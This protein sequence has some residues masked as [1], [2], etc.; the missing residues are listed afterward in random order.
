MQYSI[1]LFFL[2][3]LTVLT[4]ACEKIIEP[5]LAEAEP[6][7]VLEANLSKRDGLVVNITRSVSYFATDAP[8]PITDAFVIL[9]S[10]DGTELTVPHTGEGRYG[11]AVD[12]ETAI[13][14]TLTVVVDGA[15]YTARSTLLP[16]PELLGLDTEFQPA[17][18]PIDAG[19]IVYFTYRDRPGVPDY[20][21]VLHYVDGVPQ[22][23]GDDLQI[24]ND[25]RNDGLEPRFPV[26]GHTFEDGRTIT[27]ELIRFDRAVHDYFS[28]L[29]E[30]ISEGGPGGGTAAPG[31]PPS[32][33]SGGALGYFGAF[34]R[35]ALEVGL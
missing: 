3:A 5:D 24:L 6:Q 26:F 32:N 23:T 14:Y 34:S 20:Y 2:I 25:N 7:L 8:T 4:L 10:D 11:L 16:A 31:N 15:T 21:R 27:I 13:T 12:P 18:G 33:W 1:Q 29:A 19:N 28:G 17:A 35:D 22:L 30:I 9:S